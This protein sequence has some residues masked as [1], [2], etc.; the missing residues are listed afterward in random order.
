MASS[1]KSYESYKSKTVQELFSE[2]L[3]EDSSEDQPWS[4]VSELHVRGTPEIFQIAQNFCRSTDPRERVVGLD[5]LAQLGCSEGICHDERVSIALSHMTDEDS[6]VVVSA[7]Y[8]LSHL[9][10]DRAVSA[11]VGVKR[12]P[13]SAV[14]HAVAV[15][16]GGEKRPDAIQALIELI[17]DEDEDV[18]NWATFGLGTQ[19]VSEDS[20]EIRQALRG[21]LSD[22]F[23][24]ACDEAIWGLAKRRDPQALEILI[25]RLE[26]DS[27]KSGDEMAAAEV[28]QLGGD[29]PIEALL[30]GLAGESRRDQKSINPGLNGFLLL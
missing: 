15:G 23:E 29:A 21:G 3:E 28:L 4:A 13:D 12:H 1:E 19:S 11:L 17:K 9:G 8:A 22:S 10:G 24:E 6:R 20:P 26:A 18:R 7:A 5:V 2:A 16:M 27:W 25:Q 30:S 14:R